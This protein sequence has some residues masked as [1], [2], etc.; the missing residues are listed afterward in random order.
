MLLADLKDAE[1]QFGIGQKSHM[2][3]L[4]RF[5]QLHFTSISELNSEFESNLSKLKSEFRKERKALNAI[6]SSEL[7]ELGGIMSAISEENERRTLES[8]QVCMCV[9]GRGWGLVL[10]CVSVCVVGWMDG[11]MNGLG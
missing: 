10:C 4:E 6:Q 7:T 1:E 3:A 2:A 9:C 8:Q 11:W 5:N